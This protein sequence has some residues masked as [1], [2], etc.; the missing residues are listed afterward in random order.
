MVQALTAS[1]S[2][3]KTLLLLQYDL[4]TTWRIAILIENSMCIAIHIG[5]FLCTGI[6]ISNYVLFCYTYCKEETIRDTYCVLLFQEQYMEILLGSSL[7]GNVE[8]VTRT[9]HGYGSSRY[10]IGIPA[11]GRS[12]ASTSLDK[13]YDYVSKT[14]LSL[15][16][17][18]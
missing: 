11:H 14:Q 15:Y 17:N 1:Q 16:Q 13:I 5:D 2:L 6:L 18:A 8:F 3:W 4:Q 10:R 12:L 7:V 9:V